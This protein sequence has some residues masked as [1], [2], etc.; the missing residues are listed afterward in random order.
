[1]KNPLI[2]LMRQV[3]RFRFQ[4]RIQFSVTIS[5]SR[6]FTETRHSFNSH[7][8]DPVVTEPIGN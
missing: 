7:G 8:I 2:K 4:P 1:M 3:P 6:D 5:I